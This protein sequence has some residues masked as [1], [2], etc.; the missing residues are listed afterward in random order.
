MEIIKINYKERSIMEFLHCIHHINHLPEDVSSHV[1]A[2][3]LLQPVTAI[4]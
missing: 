1:G 4:Y 3:S 2:F